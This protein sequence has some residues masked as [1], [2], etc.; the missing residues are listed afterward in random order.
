M[1]FVPPLG[2]TAQHVTDI[3]LTKLQEYNISI[4]DS[5]AYNNASAMVRLIAFI[6]SSL[7]QLAVSR[8]SKNI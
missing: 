4:Q 1:D 7:H 3:I 8:N 2:K 5:Q 6:I